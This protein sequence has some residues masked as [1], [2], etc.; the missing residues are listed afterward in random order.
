VADN[1]QEFPFEELKKP[2]GDFFASWL[3][4]SLAGY[5]DCNI[6][7][8]VAGDISLSYGPPHHI[9]NV[10]GFVATKEAH[11][12]ETYYHEPVDA[13]SLAEAL[14]LAGAAFDELQTNKTA[15][16]YLAA[17]LDAET[18]GIIDDED[19]RDHLV[20]IRDFLLND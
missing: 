5:K 4:A 20:G 10:I 12:N 2:S 15:G 1:Y 6:W 19:F 18:E 3:E 13:N 17:L 16:N 8:I 7:S 14:G 11:D 9:V